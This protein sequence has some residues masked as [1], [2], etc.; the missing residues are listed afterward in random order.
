VKDLNFNKHDICLDDII[1][2]KSYEGA[3]RFTEQPKKGS[4]KIPRLSYSKFLTIFSEIVLH[5]I[6]RNLSSFHQPLAID[7]PPPSTPSLPPSLPVPT[8]SQPS[9]LRENADTGEPMETEESYHISR[10]FISPQRGPPQQQRIT[11]T[12]KVTPPA[13]ATP[14]PEVTSP[15]TPEITSPPEDTTLKPFL[16]YLNKD[17]VI[18][19][20]IMICHF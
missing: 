14:T 2:W 13:A 3:K 6:G 7:P 5:F 12:L 10:I 11:P 15:P 9:V 16:A 18:I 17:Y 19:G 8:Q 1:S 20:G 4:L